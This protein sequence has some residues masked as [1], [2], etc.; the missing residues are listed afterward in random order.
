MVIVWKTWMGSSTFW[1]TGICTLYS[2]DAV[3]SIKCKK[4]HS[5]SC[6]LFFCILCTGILGI[7]NT[8]VLHWINL[9]NRI[10][11]KYS[12]LGKNLS[13]YE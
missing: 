3:N 1:E 4:N 5:Y 12:I 10:P 9:M 13:Y 7:K 11:P 2:N 8:I 6:L